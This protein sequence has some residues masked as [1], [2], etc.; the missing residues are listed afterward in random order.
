MLISFRFSIIIKALNELN[1]HNELPVLLRNKIDSYLKVYNDISNDQFKVFHEIVVNNNRY[2]IQEDNLFFANLENVLTDLIP[3]MLTKSKEL[4]SE[5]NIMTKSK[6][7]EA[8]I[9]AEKRLKEVIPPNEVNN[10]AAD[11]ISIINSGW[12]VKLMYK[13]SLSKKVGKIK[14]ENGDYDLNLLIN[15]LMKYSLRT[16]RI[17]RRWGM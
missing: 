17:Q 1:L 9:L 13:E 12:F 2:K 5:D 3:G 7:K 6:L 10:I 14:E 8:K 11:P 16:S 15:D 4:L